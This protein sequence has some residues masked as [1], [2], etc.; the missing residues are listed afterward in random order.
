MTI[1]RALSNEK[2]QIECGCRNKGKRGR[3]GTG[4]TVPANT[5]LQMDMF[6]CT[7]TY[8]TVTPKNEEHFEK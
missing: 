2:L 5:I 7:N 6:Q 1:A 3:I 8:V 4:D